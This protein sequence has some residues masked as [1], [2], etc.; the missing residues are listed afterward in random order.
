MEQ[1]S[2]NVQSMPFA[3]FVWIL[4]HLARTLGPGS[5]TNVTFS[6]DEALVEINIVTQHHAVSLMRTAQRVA[7]LM[8]EGTHCDIETFPI[9]ATLVCIIRH[10]V[11]ISQRGILERTGNLLVVGGPRVQPV[12]TK[13][14]QLHSTGSTA[15]RSMG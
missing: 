5:K 12:R 11:D 6:G 10:F 2:Q 15:Q 9:R 8:H 3:L 7:N 4:D 14:G 1:E 13:D